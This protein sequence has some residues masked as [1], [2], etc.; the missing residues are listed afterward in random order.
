MGI[1]A[2]RGGDSFSER[3]GFY[4]NSDYFYS[5]IVDRL[6]GVM[7]V[8]M[9]RDFQNCGRFSVQAFRISFF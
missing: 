9:G 5:V 8:A 2:P 1:V 3:V 7:F 6:G 4:F